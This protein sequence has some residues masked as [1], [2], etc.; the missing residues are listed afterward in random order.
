MT[1][2][3][4]SSVCKEYART[5]AMS[6][7]ALPF[8]TAVLVSTLQRTEPTYIYGERQRDLF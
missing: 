1:L 4:N 2:S 8:S 3:L 7:K 5:F 6:A